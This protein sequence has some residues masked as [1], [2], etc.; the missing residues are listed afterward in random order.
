[1]MR[2]KR[3]HPLAGENLANAL[4]KRKMF[5]VEHSIVCGFFTFSRQQSIAFALTAALNVPR[6]TESEI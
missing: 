4:R 1:M 6:G 5:H 3:F 2:D